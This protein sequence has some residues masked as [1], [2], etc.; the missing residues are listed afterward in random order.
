MRPP[1]FGYEALAAD[2]R[3]ADRVDDFARQFRA[4]AAER[5]MPGDHRRQNFADD[6]IL[7]FK[8]SLF[9]ALADQVKAHPSQ[10]GFLLARHARA[11]Q[12]LQ[13][14]DLSRMSVRT[15]RLHRYSA[16]RHF[17]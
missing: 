3:V 15:L 13:A 9:E 5:K 1:E 8:P 6:R 2:H 16:L 17:Q 11:S 7:R 14:G 12:P 10:G 4:A